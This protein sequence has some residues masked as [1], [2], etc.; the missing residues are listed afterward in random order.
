MLV[1]LQQHFSPP[2]VFRFQCALGGLALGLAYGADQGDLLRELRF[3][4][5]APNLDPSL[6]PN[7]DPK[8]NPSL[9]RDLESTPHSTLWNTIAQGIETVIQSHLPLPDPAIGLG[10][11]DL[12]PLHYLPWIC[13]LAGDRSSQET[14]LESISNAHQQD[15]IVFLIQVWEMYLNSPPR[16]CSGFSPPESSRESSLTV[17]KAWT[18]LHQC[19]QELPT[20]SQGV[21]Q[22]GILTE[23]L[24]L[25]ALSLALWLTLRSD[26]YFSLSLAQVPSVFSAC[27]TGFPSLQ[28]KLW[29][30][31][32]LVAGFA[33]AKIPWDS[34]PLT[35]RSRLQTQGDRL[36][37]AWAGQIV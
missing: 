28:R 14:L 3:S 19:R 22:W 36:F 30:Y 11:S 32:G 35:E 31:T 13:V 4:G 25:Y 18:I 29:A 23:N 21:G 7:L 12:L 1:T 26:G 34:L 6:D 10:D 9:D 5:L 24:D 8:L 16:S 37:R 20:L 2:I 27:P 17:Q 33:T 15:A